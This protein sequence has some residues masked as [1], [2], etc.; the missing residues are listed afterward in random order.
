ML[1]RLYFLLLC[2][3]SSFFFS[4]RRGHSICALVTG[5]QTCALPIYPAADRANLPADPEEPRL[6]RPA[7]RERCGAVGS[8][9][10]VW[11][12]L[13][14]QHAGRLPQSTVWLLAVLP[15][16]RGAAA[17][18]H[19]HGVQGERKSGVSGTRVSV[20]VETGGRRIIT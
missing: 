2:W 15:E 18:H 9:A 12:D 13:H 16:K 10:V 19:G 11:R 6:H 1:L 8:A 7:R 3:H 20:G 4:R 14:G 5:V 17:D